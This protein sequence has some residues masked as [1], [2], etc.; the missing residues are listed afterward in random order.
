MISSATP[1]GNVRYTRRS[2]GTYQASNALSRVC[3]KSEEYG[4]QDATISQEVPR[5]PDEATEMGKQFAVHADTITAFA[6]TQLVGFMLLMTHG[7]CFTRNVLSGLWDDYHGQPFSFRRS[8]VLSI[9]LSLRP[10][11]GS[12]RGLLGSF[13]DHWR[14]VITVYAGMNR[15]ATLSHITNTPPGELGGQFWLQL[16]SFGIGPLVGLLTTLFP[17][18]PEFATSWLQP[19]VQALK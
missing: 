17:S 10:T 13:L 9:Q 16:I 4:R 7:D 15:D 19:S 14:A 11:P 6:T 2:S 1:L 3:S 8:H 18:I 5:M 12:G